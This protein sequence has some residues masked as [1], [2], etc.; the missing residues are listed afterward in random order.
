MSASCWVTAT[1][2]TAAVFSS[3]D[4]PTAQT[5]PIAMAVPSEASASRADSPMARDRRAAGRHHLGEPSHLP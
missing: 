5:T 3:D 1:R 2:V 4:S